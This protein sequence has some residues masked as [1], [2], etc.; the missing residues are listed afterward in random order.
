[1]SIV[2]DKDN[3]A[4]KSF[5]NNDQVKFTGGLAC[6]DPH[7]DVLWQYIPERCVIKCYNRL[8]VGA[9]NIKECSVYE[10]LFLRETGEVTLTAIANSDKRTLSILSSELAIPTVHNGFITRNQMAIHMLACLDTFYI[11]HSQG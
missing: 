8:T 9:K 6:L 1:M 10:S 2:I 7:H 5:S 4:C 11:A 3:G